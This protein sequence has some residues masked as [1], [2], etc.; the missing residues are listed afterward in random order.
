MG[1]LWVLI[2]FN[3]QGFF[4]VV[5][6]RNINN[7]G[8][9]VG[10]DNEIFGQSQTDIESKTLQAIV[11]NNTITIP[12]LSHVLNITERQVQRI[13][14]KLRDKMLIERKGGRKQGYWEVKK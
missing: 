9:D 8:K 5:F 7:V 12:E 6:K 13:I 4:K 2:I 1:R 11:E 10:K 3:S 14:R